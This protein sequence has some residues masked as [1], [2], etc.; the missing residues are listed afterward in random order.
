MIKRGL[1]YSSTSIARVEDFI[2]SPELCHGRE[3]RGKDEGTVKDQKRAADFHTMC[4]ST[5]YPSLCRI[6]TP[7]SGMLVRFSEGL[8]LMMFATVLHTTSESSVMPRMVQMV[9]TLL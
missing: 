3:P 8:T 4:P 9:G 7:S 6:C 2:D 5:N 1:V